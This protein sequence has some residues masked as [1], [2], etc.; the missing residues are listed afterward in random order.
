[1]EA[2]SLTSLVKLINNLQIQQPE[3]SFTLS[4][5]LSLYFFFFLISFVLFFVFCFFGGIV[6]VCGWSALGG[7]VWVFWTTFEWIMGEWVI[8]SWN[9]CLL[10]MT[11]PLWSCCW[12]FN[13]RVSYQFDKRSYGPQVSSCINDIQP[14][15]ADNF[16]NSFFIFFW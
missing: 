3:I 6:M 4:L 11:R 1:M 12:C 9:I 10:L 13:L 8:G 16:K 14:S 15:K 5:S 7:F 2:K